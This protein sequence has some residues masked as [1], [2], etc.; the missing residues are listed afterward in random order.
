[1]ALTWPEVQARIERAREGLKSGQYKIRRVEPLEGSE[2]RFI[3]EN[4]D[5]VPYAVSF[6]GDKPTGACTCPDFIGRK[7]PACKHTAMVVLDQWP[8][9][10]ERWAEKVRALCK[11]VEALPEEPQQ[12]AVDPE[13]KSERFAPLT[14]PTVPAEVVE[15]AVRKAVHDALS[16]LEEQLVSI[17]AQEVERAVLGILAQP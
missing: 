17:I 5:G 9:A 8:D 13:A 2:S 14:P 10:F 11:P 4:G 3:I 15:A 16:A 12:P 6:R 7:G 1:M